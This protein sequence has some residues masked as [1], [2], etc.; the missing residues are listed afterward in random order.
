MKSFLKFILALCALNINQAIADSKPTYVIG[1]ENIT[2][3]PYYTVKE[4][5]EYGAFARD[6]FDLFAKKSNIQFKYEPM[7]VARLFKEYLGGGLDFKYPDSSLWMSEGRKNKNIIYSDNVVEYID[8]AIIKAEN[9]NKDISFI[10]KL[11]T[12]R[13]FEVGEYKKR[14]IQIEESSNIPELI[15]KLDNNKIDAVFF[16]VAVALN[17]VNRNKY[18]KNKFIFKKEY[19]YLHD[20][21]RLS[22]MKH[23]DVIDKFN[24]FLKKNI[25][26]INEMKKKNKIIF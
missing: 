1:V 13:G 20:Y 9:K 17:Y 25:K 7:P 22:T 5:G 19:P 3:D 6:I 15:D 11:G 10:K 23:K 18:F 16:N 12:I 8:G 14:Q 4:N 24:L 2:Y 26:E 21:Y